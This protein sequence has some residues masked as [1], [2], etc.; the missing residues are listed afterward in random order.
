MIAIIGY[1]LGNV[2]AIRNMLSRI[3]APCTIT[4]DPD[5][6]RAAT[7]LLL[8]GIG[9]F[10]A[11]MERL[12]ASG[13]VPLLNQR[14]LDE[15][16]PVLGICLGMQLMTHGSAEGIAPGLGWVNA[17]CERFNEHPGDGLPL[18]VPHMRWNR[19]TPVRPTPLLDP[20]DPDPC[21][22]YFTHSYHVV[23]RD[24]ALLAGTT[25]YRAMLCSVQT[26][27]LR[28]SVA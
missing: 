4:V 16:I 24:P 20:S 28:E 12:H 17:H 7:H 13:L 5:E 27:M 8:P 22:F 19:V 2:G 14:V 11:G 26:A 23:C 10:D 1:G 21:W 3:G 18:R 6:I 9:S 25:Q 15:R